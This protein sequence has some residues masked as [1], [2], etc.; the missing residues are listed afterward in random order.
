MRTLS[1]Q[2]PQTGNRITFDLSRRVVAQ[3]LISPRKM[4]GCG[5]Y[6]VCPLDLVTS[7]FNQIFV[8]AVEN[9]APRLPVK[10]IRNLFQIPGKSWKYTMLSFP[11]ISIYIY[12]HPKSNQK[13]SSQTCPTLSHQ[14]SSC[15]ESMDPEC[16]N[17]PHRK[18][19]WNISPG[20]PSGSLESPWESPGG[21][22]PYSACSLSPQRISAGSNGRGPCPGSRSSGPAEMAP[23]PRELLRR[24][25]HHSGLG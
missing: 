6:D 18:R 22:W 13:M 17:S 24:T 2:G 23:A 1:P 9:R 4:S 16:P 7:F 25:G 21:A 11:T 8:P 19:A 12:I 15:T 3:R 14:S 20:R 5:R 10:H